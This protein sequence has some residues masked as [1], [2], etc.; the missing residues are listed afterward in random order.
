MVTLQT[1]CSAKQDEGIARRGEGLEET[2]REQERGE[3]RGETRLQQQSVHRT[4]SAELKRGVVDERNS[5]FHL[6]SKDSMTI[7]LPLIQNYF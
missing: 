6:L 7:L 1:L 2:F 3:P 5:S 4:K